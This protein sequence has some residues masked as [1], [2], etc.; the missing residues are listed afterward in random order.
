MRWFFLNCIEFRD[1]WNKIQIDIF[2]P[3]NFKFLRFFNSNQ[4]NAQPNFNSTPTQFFHLKRAPQTH[5]RRRG[6][7]LREPILREIER[8]SSYQ[9]PQ[10]IAGHRTENDKTIIFRQ[11]KPGQ[12]ARRPDPSLP[13][14]W[15]SV[16][17]HHHLQCI[18]QIPYQ[19]IY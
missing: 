4:P 5:D 8:T 6:W 2:C 1:E 18:R 19:L 11:S 16:W 12:P 14:V 17:Q 13:T 9:W 15:F 3:K 7:R 10:L